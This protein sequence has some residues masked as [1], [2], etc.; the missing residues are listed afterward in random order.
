M[1]NDDFSA[2]EASS[3]WSEDEE[4]EDD[5]RQAGGKDGI[6]KEMEELKK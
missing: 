5:I 1:T 3:D 6:K 4:L 2:S